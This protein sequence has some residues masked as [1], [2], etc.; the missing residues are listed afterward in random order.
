M[1]DLSEK[2]LSALQDLL[3]DESLLTKKFKML[4]EHTEDTEIKKQYMNISAKHQEHFD[5][6]YAKLS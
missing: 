2:E 4:A 5:R 6:L 3:N 1:N